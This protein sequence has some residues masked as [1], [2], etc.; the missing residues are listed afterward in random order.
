MPLRLFTPR[1]AR[2]TRKKSLPFKEGITSPRAHEE[3]KERT[4]SGQKGY[5]LPEIGLE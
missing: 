2:A 4:H 5:P 3:A 1:C